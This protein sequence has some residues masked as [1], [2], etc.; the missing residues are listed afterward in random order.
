MGAEVPV[1]IVPGR[2]YREHL[3]HFVLRPVPA[4]DRDSAEA[5]LDLNPF[6]SFLPGKEEVTERLHYYDQLYRYQGHR[7]A[8]KVSEYDL[9]NRHNRQEPVNGLEAAFI[10][11]L[12]ARAFGA[13]RVR[14]EVIEGRVLTFSELIEE[15]GDIV[16]RTFAADR[17]EA[18]LR[19]RD[20]GVLVIQGRPGLGETALLAHLVERYGDSMPPASAWGST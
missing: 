8:A 19:E 7:R 10:A 13:S 17:V 11:E 20:R 6:L 9:G 18:F 15:H 2:F 16:G 12:L 1:G 14:M 4:A 3:G 5:V